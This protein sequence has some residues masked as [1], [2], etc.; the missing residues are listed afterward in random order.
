L[1][2]KTE[3]IFCVEYKILGSLVTEATA[4]EAFAGAV[5][6]FLDAR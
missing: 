4:V 2:S 1:Q 6:M 5:V 3:H